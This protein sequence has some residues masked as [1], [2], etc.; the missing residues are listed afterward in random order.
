MGV[1]DLNISKALQILLSKFPVVSQWIPQN[2]T[3]SEDFIVW[4]IRLPRIV[5]SVFAGAALSVCGAAYQ[6][7]FR[8]PLTDPY[9]LG[10]SSGASLGASLAILFG[11]EHYLL[12]ISGVALITAL[13]TVFLIYRLA[14]IGNRLHTATLLLSGISLTFLAAAIISF[15]IVI[16]QDKM[17]KIIFWT[18]GSFSS[19]NWSSTSIVIPFTLLGII[20]VLS[21]AKELNILLTGSET[22]RSLG[23]ETEKVKKRLLFFST[24]MIAF[25]VSTCG[26]IGFVGLVVPHM[27]RLIT[28]ADNRLVIP[29]SI[30]A[31]AIFLLLA[32]TFARTVMQPAELPV[33]S[34]TALIGAPFFIYL[35]Y[36]A[37]KKL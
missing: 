23:V 30:F 10:V 2:Y 1:A 18:M 8:N 9:I 19:V 25:V 21:Y 24:V 37:K 26:V 5:L 4:Q 12:G 20:I 34:I 16:R 14:S 32:D 22:A 13:L 27:V 17:D 3:V 7:I 33:G 28:G 36:R 31:G 15:I 35:L 6:S 29:Y 11:L